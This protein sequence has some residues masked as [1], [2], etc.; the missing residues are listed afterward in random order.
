MWSNEKSSLVHQFCQIKIFISQSQINFLYSKKGKKKVMY[1][2]IANLQ[3]PHPLQWYC[4][5]ETWKNKWISKSGYKNNRKSDS[6]FIRMK[7]TPNTTGLHT[8]SSN[9]LQ[10]PQKYFPIQTPQF[11]QICCTCHKQRKPWRKGIS[12]VTNCK[13]K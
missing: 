5:F 11:M 1:K 4:C 3:I 10:V 9:N 2:A 13:G 6:S 7:I 8:S 12:T